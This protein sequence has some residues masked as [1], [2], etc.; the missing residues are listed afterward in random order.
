MKPK[1]SLVRQ[2]ELFTFWAVLKPLTSQSNQILLSYDDNEI[3]FQM[4]KISNDVS[5]SVIPALPISKRNPDTNRYAVAN[6]QTALASA[7][8][9][10]RSIGPFDPPLPVGLKSLALSQARH[11]ALSTGLT[12]PYTD[13]VYFISSLNV[14]IL[15]IDNLLTFHPI[16]LVSSTIMIH[17][18]VYK[19]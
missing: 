6:S 11:F 18:Y 10:N 1:R 5:Y 19:W 9:I 7:W 16:S 2:W 8:A 3:C 12:S 17:V 15:G 14:L 4:K 13:L